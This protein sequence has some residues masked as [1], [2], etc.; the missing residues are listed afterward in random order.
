[1]QV[2]K[3]NTRGEKYRQL[4]RKYTTPS[5]KVKWFATKYWHISAMGI[6]TG[7]VAHF[8]N[9]RP[10]NQYVGFAIGAWVAAM[11]YPDSDK[12]K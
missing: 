1:M 4:L 10:I 12:P 5:E 11:F 8:N 9:N 6:T 7:A 2:D 3:P